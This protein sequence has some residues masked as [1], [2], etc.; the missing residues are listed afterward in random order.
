MVEKPVFLQGAFGFS[1]TGLDKPSAF[2][3]ALSYKV[4]FDKRAQLVYFRAGNASAELIYVVLMR[5]SKPMR[6]FPIGAKGATHV[7]LAVVEDLQPDTVLEVVLAAPEGLSDSVLLDMGL[8][9]IEA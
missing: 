1:G 8:V 4:P 3:P 2:K 7:E 6:Y 5:D 9:E